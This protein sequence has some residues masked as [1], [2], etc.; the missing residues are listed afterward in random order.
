MSKIKFRKATK[1]DIDRVVEIYENFLD[2]EAEHGTYTNWVKGLYPTVKNAENGLKNGT[3]FVGEL[4]GNIVGSYVLNN[5]QPEEYGKF[6]WAYEG[7][8]QQVIVIHTMC[9]DMY[10]QGMGLG[11]QFVEFA[12]EYGKSHGCKTMRL[13]TA[14]INKPAAKLYNSMGFRYV[15]KTEFYFEQAILEDLICFE[16]RLDGPM[17]FDPLD[18]EK[19]LISDVGNLDTRKAPRKG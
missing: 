6:S 14:D 19:R 9:L 18:S 12:M 1:N 10:T 17:D 4:D 3:L 15:G 16:Y 11:R 7:H 2:Y 5:T 13:D 8:G